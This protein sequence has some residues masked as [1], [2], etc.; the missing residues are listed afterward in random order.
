MDG[1]WRGALAAWVQSRKRYPDEARRQG[2]EGQVVIRFTVG[3]DGAVLAAD[4]VRGSGSA[5]LDEAARA[6]FVG[7]RAPPFPAGMAQAQLTT[8]VAVRY[9][10]SE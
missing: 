10:L 9:R 4:I 5:V 6:M 3:R 2:L 7:G 1:A 8:T